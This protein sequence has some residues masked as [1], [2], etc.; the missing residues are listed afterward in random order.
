[1]QPTEHI[2]DHT[3][4]QLALMA[5]RRKQAAAP[6]VDAEWASFRRKH[7]TGEQLPRDAQ[8]RQRR[9]TLLKMIGAAL[10]GAAAMFV[11]TILY[12][13]LHEA[14]HDI[15]VFDYDRA[16]QHIT[17]TTAQTQCD[18]T[19]RDSI[20][21]LA[22]DRPAVTATPS[23]AAD[24]PA[25]T[26]N[27]ALQRLTTPRGMDFKILLGDGTEVW[28]NA[29]SSIEFP[30]AF[31]GTERRVCLTG[32]AY[33]KVAPNAER[34][35]I[36]NLG[37]KQVR[38]LGT[39]FDVRNY[40]AEYSSVVLVSGSVQLEDG[41]GLEEATLTPG[42][43]ATWNVGCDATIHEVDT[44]SATQWI[45]G[46]FYFEEHSLGEVLREVGRWYNY[47]VTFKDKRHMSYKIHFSASRHDDITE[48]I[49]DLN[50]LCNFRLAIEGKNITVY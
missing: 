37:D 48:I 46:L 36:V 41:E 21:F 14:E 35:F 31:T 15:V 27:E 34:P 40:S 2:T 33:F 18:L 39:E 26:D 13:H 17:L 11:G 19:Q 1:M 42:Q 16:P 49:N 38:V 9:A 30:A 7:M 23:A 10:S 12:L 32:E 25:S 6:D 4:K 28:L 3:L 8:S 43:G 5:E 24:S 44:Y 50:T 20:S 29:E 45:D 47:G 22:A